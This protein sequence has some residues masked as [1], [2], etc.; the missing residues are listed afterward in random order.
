MADI[1]PPS[2]PSM[3]SSDAPPGGGLSVAV[4]GTRKLLEGGV[5]LVPGCAG[6]SVACWYF[7]S[8]F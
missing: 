4:W 8:V 1:F 5:L 7:L 6:T 3:P 2:C